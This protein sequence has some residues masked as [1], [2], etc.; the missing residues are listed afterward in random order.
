MQLY[1]YNLKALLF[2]INV[3]CIQNIFGQQLPPIVNYTQKDYNAHYQNWNITQDSSGLVYFGNTHGLLTFNGNLWK[4]DQLNGNKAVRSVF[5]Y[6]EK[7]FTGAYDEFGYWS[8]EN[9]E[10]RFKS[11]KN[12]IPDNKLQKEEIWNIIDCYGKLYLQSFSVLMV[13]DGKTIK[14]IKT[15]DNFMFA[16]KVSGELFI[17]ILG[18]GI[19]KIKQD[20]T[21][22]FLKN[23]ELFS[24]KIVT[25]IIKNKGYLIVSTN[26]HGIFTY[27]NGKVTVW[28]NDLQNYFESVQ[29][30]R[31]LL[32]REGKMCVGTISDGLL[33]FDENG[34]LLVHINKANGLNNNT[35][36]HIFEDR[37]KNIWCG[38]DNGISLIRLNSNISFYKDKS[39]KIGNI[40]TSVKKDSILYIGTNH[41][42]FYYD[43]SLKNSVYKD[44]EFELIKGTQGQVWQLKKI[45]DKIICGHNDGTFLIDKY[46]S[47]KISGITGGW[48]MNEVNKEIFIQSTYTGFCFY[49]NEKGW[50]SEAKRVAGFELP[51]K[52]FIMLN[53]YEAIGLNPST[54]LYHFYFNNDYS[55]II[56]WNKLFLDDDNENKF[57]IDLSKVGNDIYVLENGNQYLYNKS[58][59]S[60]TKIN[61]PERPFK[62]REID[63]I[64]YFK[65]YADS[66]K[67]I[68]KYFKIKIP[69]QINQEYFSSTKLSDDSY[70][71]SIDEGYLVIKNVGRKNQSDVNKN[72]LFD[73]IE[74]NGVKKYFNKQKIELDYAERSFKLFL[75]LSNYASSAD[76]KV[77]LEK[78]DEF[79]R[80]MENKP[81]VEYYNLS[82]G[83]YTLQAISSNG[84]S[85]EEFLVII[86][87]PWYNSKLSFFLY[88]L[89]LIIAGYYIKKYFDKQLISEKLKL[90]AENKRLLHEHLIELENTRLHEQNIL[91]SKELANTT[92]HLI[93][94]NEIL[95]EIKSDLTDL[96]KSGQALQSNKEFQN[97]VKR[98]D[99]NL[100]VEDDKNLFETNFEEVHHDFLQ[101][102]ENEFPELTKAD[103]KLAAYLRMDLSSKEICPLLN[104]SLRGLENKRY[105]LRKKLSLGNEINLS[106][107][108]Q[109]YN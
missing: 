84:G 80:S 20:D 72:I 24:D 70:L 65:I 46:T 19:Y 101:K 31:L 104:I 33:I 71:F 17:Q 108:F 107:Y 18:K 16:Q 48:C 94:K 55:K 45:G 43:L 4:L 90:E 82:P 52:K 10:L 77:S 68:D 47:I 5:Y 56:H 3:L 99:F 69:Y 61:N 73:F 36:L 23:T 44:R 13:Y 58:S 50:F 40:F 6:R 86:N 103:L 37:E 60:F 95:N 92:M 14:H 87:Q 78:D 39:G 7:I 27:K 2:V 57:E 59:S 26:S 11:L 15:P 53:Q 41:G 74:A 32:T 21:L 62:Y 63:S 38:L 97:L 54:G 83:H 89:I 67:I 49:R 8:K 30:N 29:I 35:V 81:Y 76:L 25:G 85:T 106:T 79:Y 12:L 22:E 1:A 9:H 109:K 64:C 28:K 96:R 75:H 66:F 51:I 91:K 34:D 100:S 93:Q 102:L 98:I 105:R 88:F 42:V